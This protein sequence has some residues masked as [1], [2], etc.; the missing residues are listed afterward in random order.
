[1]CIPVAE[2]PLE[3]VKALSF[4]DMFPKPA[5]VAKES[6]KETESV[7]EP[8]CEPVCEPVVEKPLEPVKAL[9]FAD[10]FPKPAKKLV[11]KK[12]K[13]QPVFG[14]LWIFTFRWNRHRKTPT[15]MIYVTNR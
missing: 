2:K 12:S 5:M 3:L 8:V 9:S 13:P 11:K 7:R 15:N 4:A 6:K 1:M 14:F 10:M